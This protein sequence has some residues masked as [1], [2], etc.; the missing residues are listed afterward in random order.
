MTDEQ[1]RRISEL[2]QKS[3]TP[4]GLTEAERAEQA[5]LRRMY[6]DAMK[7]SLKSQP[8][9]TIAIDEKGRPRRLQP[10]G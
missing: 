3:R 4:Q 1:I 7:A 2:A 8:D 10:K 9:H 5:Q 6:I